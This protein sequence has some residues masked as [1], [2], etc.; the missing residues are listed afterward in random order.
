MRWKTKSQGALARPKTPWF[1]FQ[2]P[3]LSKEF[4]SKFPYFFFA[5]FFVFPYFPLFFPN[6]GMRSLPNILPSVKFPN[7]G[8]ASF[9][10]WFSC[11]SWKKNVENLEKSSSIRM[12]LTNASQVIRT[13][14][15]YLPSGGY[16]PFKDIQGNTITLLL[17]TTRTL[18]RDNRCLLCV[19]RRA[20][21]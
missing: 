19:L 14:S 2:G 15:Q 16:R 6:I 10:P 20:Q 11:F 3:F 9:F 12:A 8:N 18:V 4:L 5:Q 13:R 21:P 7:F 1:P 17:L